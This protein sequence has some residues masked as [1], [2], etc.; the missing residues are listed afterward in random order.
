MS[1]R[2]TLYF[3]GLCEPVNPG[4]AMAAGWVVVLPDGREVADSYFE[5][6]APANT[7]NTAEYC[8]LGKGLRSVINLLEADDSLPWVVDIHGDSQ[9]VINQILGTWACNKPHLARLRDRCKELIGHITGRGGEVTLRWVKRQ[10]NE[11]ADA[12]SR[13]AYRDMT[14]KEPPSRAA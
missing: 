7:N 5:P 1:Y 13:Q 10:M 3:D 11:K 2:I 14:G 9:L 12:L 6:A 8:G 4:G